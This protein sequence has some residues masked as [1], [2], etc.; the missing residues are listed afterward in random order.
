MKEIELGIRRKDNLARI[1][2]LRNM[3][4]HVNCYH[5]S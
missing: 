1:T 2:A 4:R 5:T 3:M